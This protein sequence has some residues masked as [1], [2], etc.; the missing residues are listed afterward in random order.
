MSKHI[1]VPVDGS[2]LSRQALEI[3]CEEYDDG[4]IT[5]LH[6]IDPT[7]PGYSVY[8]VDQEPTT[9]PR[10]GSDSW[11]ENAHAYAA[12][13]FEELSA[14]AATAGVSLETVTTVGRPDRDI[15]TYTADNDVD[16][17]MLG[18]HSRDEESPLLLGT[19]TEAVVFRSPVRVSV[20]R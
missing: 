1:L 17:I 7:E 4:K 9:T 8:G 5:A 6:V 2:P 15:L 19:I 10:Q 3:A 13:L 20:I 14:V 12:E 18:S 11:Y 16:Q